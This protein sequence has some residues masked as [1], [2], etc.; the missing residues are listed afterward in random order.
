MPLRLFDTLSGAVA[1]VRSPRGRPFT[2]Y[3][4]GPTVYD[5]AH[6]GH[7]RT[8]L[9]FDVVRRV[10]EGEGVRVRHIMNITD[11]EDKVTDRAVSLG[12]SWRELALLEE[13]KFMA[14]LDRLRVL[15]PH[16]RPRASSYV[17]KMMRVV[18]EMERRGR[19]SWRGDSLLYVPPERPD[20]RNFAIGAE[21]AEHAVA[22]SEGPDVG[23]AAREFLLWRRQLAPNASWS[24]RWGEG[25][26]GWHLECYCM[27]QELLGLPVDLHG[28][29]V[30]LIFPHHYNE[31]EVALTLQGK[32][33]AHRYLHTAFVTN[34]GEKMSK[35][36][37]RFVP[38][39]PLLD[40]YGPD[41]LR[42][43]LLSPSYREGLEYDARALQ[44]SARE[45]DRIHQLLRW[46]LPTGAGG[47]V[48]LAAL[49]KADRAIRGALLDG[50][51]IG[52]AFDELRALSERI[53][54]D[55]RGQFPKGDGRVVRATLA[56]I[57]RRLGTGFGAAP[58][59]G[60]GRA[61]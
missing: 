59:G 57:D 9:Y 40:R 39:R 54:R 53:A 55:G 6:V 8:Y 23:R 41:A 29:G 25:A 11:F 21:L 18:R 34:R 4:C 31:N 28:G 60:A 42:L 49:E 44:R 32:R 30:D 15:P 7:A 51:R 19:A 17:P 13:R 14:D 50:L 26:P 33:F 58:K 35:S 2:L 37:G 47:A 38:L 36:T 22:D 10:L 48:P 43:Y 46:S 45:A 52:N 12:Q 1:P 16:R 5:G 61:K 56:R 20:R 24:S 27:A 3:V